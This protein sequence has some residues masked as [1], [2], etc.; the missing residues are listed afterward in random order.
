MKNHNGIDFTRLEKEGG[1]YVA[2]VNYG[3]YCP[4]DGFTVTKVAEDL[5]NPKGAQPNGGGNYLYL[6][7]DDILFD[8]D[9]RGYRLYLGFLHAEK[10]FVKEGDKPKKGEL[11]M[12]AD[13]TGFSTGRHT[14]ISAFRLDPV[15]M[16]KMDI[17]EANNS[18]DPAQYWDGTY[19]Q[20]AVGVSDWIFW[21]NIITLRNYQ[22]VRRI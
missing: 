9:N 3:V 8:K 6:L 1:G 4:A 20:D 11:L 13:S 12:L 21:K 15:T 10:I 19:A 7:S 2:S 22:N 17:N 18:T 5:T 16:E 14:H